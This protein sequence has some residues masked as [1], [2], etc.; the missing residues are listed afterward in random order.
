MNVRRK[1]NLKMLWHVKS[2][3][4]GLFS[5]HLRKFCSETSSNSWQ[6]KEASRWIVNCEPVKRINYQEGKLSR[7]LREEII[8]E[9]NMVN[10]I[11]IRLPLPNRRRVLE[12]SD[13]LLGCYL[14]GESIDHCIFPYCKCSWVVAWTH[15]KTLRFLNNQQK[16]KQKNCLHL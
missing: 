8:R 12:F 9:T 1:N 15:A 14:K 13:S 7:G 4:K 3:H 2:V 6:S 5:T 16:L 11:K 10:L